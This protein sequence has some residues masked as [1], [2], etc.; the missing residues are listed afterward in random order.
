MYGTGGRK[1]DRTRVSTHD[2]MSYI[3]N[4]FYKI[5]I[6]LENLATKRFL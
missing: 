3:H 4:E 6:T 2:G 1:S 5:K